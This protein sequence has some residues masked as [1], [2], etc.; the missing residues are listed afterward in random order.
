MMAD[1]LDSIALPLSLISAEGF[2]HFDF[3]FFHT[4]FAVFS[5]QVNIVATYIGTLD[6]SLACLAV[7]IFDDIAPTRLLRKI[8]NFFLH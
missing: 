8:V 1:G 4:G 3:D 5:T 6:L 7:L 2:I